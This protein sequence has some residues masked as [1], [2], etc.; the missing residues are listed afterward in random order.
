MSDDINMT[1][2]KE[3]SLRPVRILSWFMIVNAKM[4]TIKYH[5]LTFVFS[6]DVHRTDADA[7]GLWTFL[8]HRFH[9]APQV[10]NLT[11]LA[12][13]PV[14]VVCKPLHIKGIGIEDDIN[15]TNLRISDLKRQPTI[16]S[17]FLFFLFLLFRLSSITF[18]GINHKL[19]ISFTF[20]WFIKTRLD[21]FKTGIGDLDMI[22]EN[23]P[24]VKI[25]CQ[26][27][28]L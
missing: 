28:H 24:A 10:T 9:L 26:V 22:P 27:F 23:T 18:E 8:R 6:Q 7:P 3:T 12:S 19:E 5:L 1:D 4:Q 15:P 20:L 11:F 13:C 2:I 17:I 21:P 14:S 16:H 25:D